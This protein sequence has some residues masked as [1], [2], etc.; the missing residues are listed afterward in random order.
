MATKRKVLNRTKHNGRA[1]EEPT[2]EYNAFREA[3]AYLNATLFEGRLPAVLITL[4]RKT[5]TRGYYTAEQFETREADARADEISLNPAEFRGR[6]DE[7]I[8][9]TL[10]HEMCHHWQHQFGQPSRGRYH[11][12]EWADKMESIGLMPSH[13]GEP[14]GERTGQKMTHYI[15]E[16]GPF[17]LAATELLAGG[18]KLTW[19]DPGSG[20]A[21]KSGQN[22][23]KY[24]C[25]QC[26]LNA[27]AKPDVHLVCGSCCWTMGNP[28][29]DEP[30][31]YVP[32]PAAG[33]EVES[34]ETETDGG[35]DKRTRTVIVVP[36][37][38]STGEGT[39]TIRFPGDPPVSRVRYGEDGTLL[40]EFRDGS[41]F[42]LEA[43]EY[44]RLASLAKRKRKPFT[45][46]AEEGRYDTED[47]YVEEI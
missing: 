36:A 15:L 9:S 35:G 44:F 43:G 5:Q 33:G 47:Q 27:W 37:S 30:K 19:Q 8:L 29:G 12:T 41:Q 40:Y 4:T 23:Q 10:A 21:A 18:F 26:G 16:G 7:E 25:P 32:P 14:G 11:N 20:R 46:E 1:R 6:T 34:Y 42:A 24:T 17:D 28:E 38:K 22:K 31:A 2:E 13:T 3:F 45:A 39:V